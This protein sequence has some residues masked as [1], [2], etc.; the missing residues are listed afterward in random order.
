MAPIKTI[1]PNRNVP[2]HCHS[3]PYPPK[4]I[5]PPDVTQPYIIT[6]PHCVSLRI[7]GSN[8]SSTPRHDYLRASNLNLFI[9]IS[10]ENVA[11]SQLSIVNCLYFFAK[12]CLSFRCRLVDIGYLILERSRKPLFVKTLRTVSILIL[13][14][15]LWIVT[16]FFSSSPNRSRDFALRHIR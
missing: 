11:P 5:K 1:I 4:H 3:S 12:L 14:L 10:S 9:F 2:F 13:I 16:A 6:L 7:F 15:C 8:L